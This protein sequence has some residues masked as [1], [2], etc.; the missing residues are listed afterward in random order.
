MPAR[1][2][3]TTTPLGFQAGSRFSCSGDVL[4]NLLRAVGL[5]FSAASP[6]N[7]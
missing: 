7:R 4:V 3:T 1:P 2:Q 5:C 6:T